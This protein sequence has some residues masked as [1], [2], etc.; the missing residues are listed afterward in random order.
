M[1]LTWQAINCPYVRLL[2][3]IAPKD[4]DIQNRR[5]Q[6]R[7]CSAGAFNASP[8]PTA[9][10]ACSCWKMSNEELPHD[11]VEAIQTR[12]VAFPK[13]PGAN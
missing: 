2:A 5:D 10:D 1:Y 12:H 6:L 9:M 4:S 8:Q 7:C 3:F 11:A 13:P